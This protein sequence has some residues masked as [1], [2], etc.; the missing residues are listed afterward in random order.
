MTTTSI[1]R[2]SSLFAVAAVL[3][4]DLLVARPAA[5]EPVNVGDPFPDFSARDQ[6]GNEFTL[7]DYDGRTVLLHVCASW[8][9]PCRQSAE[10]EGA[11]TATLNYLLGSEWLLVDALVSGTNYTLASTQDDAETWRSRTPA[12]TLH[13]DGDATSDLFRFPT[14]IGVFAF[15]TYYLIEPDGIVSGYHLGYWPGISLE[16]PLDGD[17]QVLIQMTIANVAPATLID[18]FETQ[19]GAADLPTRVSTALLKQLS[20]AGSFLG[21]SDQA[22]ALRALTT[23]VTQTG[24]FATAHMI[25]A[26]TSA[27]LTAAAQAIISR[28]Q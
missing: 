16:F 15:P 27:Q 14:T 10:D 2:S 4:T 22:R 19:L 25:S 6:D 13:G 26:D 20:L 18:T 17:A 5:A 9:G 1:F 24:A 12:L 8:C 28:L 7:S 21:S 11:L 3:A 23:F